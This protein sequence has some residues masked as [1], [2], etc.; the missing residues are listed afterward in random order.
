MPYFQKYLERHIFLDADYHRPMA[1]KMLMNLLGEDPQ[2][3]QEAF[4]TA[5]H[6]IEMRIHLWDGIHQKL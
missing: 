2:N 1:E 3:F 6:A 4:D 5:A